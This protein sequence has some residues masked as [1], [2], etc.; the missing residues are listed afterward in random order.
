MTPMQHT[1]SHAAMPKRRREQPA[2]LSGVRVCP[3]PVVTTRRRA[4][5]GGRESSASTIPELNRT[6]PSRIWISRARVAPVE[7]GTPAA[8]RPGRHQRAPRTIPRS[9]ATP[10]FR[11]SPR[12]RGRVRFRGR[13]RSRRTPRFPG[14]AVRPGRCPAGSASTPRGRERGRDGRSTPTAPAR[15]RCRDLAPAC[16]QPSAPVPAHR[17][18]SGPAPARSGSVGTGVPALIPSSRPAPAPSRRSRPGPELAPAP[19]PSR[20]SP[21]AR[22]RTG[23]SARVPDRGRSPAR[24]VPAQR[25]ARPTASRRPGDP[26]TGPFGA[27]HAPRDPLADPAAADTADVYQADDTVIFD[28]QAAA[29]RA[30]RAAAPLRRNGAAA[31][32]PGGASSRASPGSPRPP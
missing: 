9:R 14:R 5:T 18:C 7:P 2:H 22:A 23:L 12:S 3:G 15:S 13:L 16:R 28:P 17:A 21:R 32:G 8:S 30:P 24:P 4:D 1:P 11:A 27:W 19:A 20:P 29:A 25:D 26:S 6:L 10:L 31:A